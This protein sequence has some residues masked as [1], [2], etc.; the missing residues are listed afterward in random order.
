VKSER[1][2]SRKYAAAMSGVHVK[3]IDRARARNLFVWKKP[4]GVRRILIELAS[5][6]AWLN[7]GGAAGI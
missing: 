2:I 7:G 1:W 5:F 6:V 3:T 4:K